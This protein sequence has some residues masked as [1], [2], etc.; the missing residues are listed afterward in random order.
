[1]IKAA[2]TNGTEIATETTDTNVLHNSTTQYQQWYVLPSQSQSYGTITYERVADPTVF[3]KALPWFGVLGLTLL[4][5]AAVAV[6]VAIWAKL[7]QEVFLGWE[8]VEEE[9]EPAAGPAEVTEPK[10]QVEVKS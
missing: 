5:L 3:H 8:T 6:L 1:M 10:E 4:A 2:A 9:A 7:I